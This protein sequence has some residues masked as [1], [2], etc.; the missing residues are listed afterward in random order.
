MAAL[1]RKEFYLIG[2]QIWS[3]IA[4][5]LLLSFI[6]QLESLG[7]S[8]LM[9][10]AIT[11]P[12]TTM[13]YDERCHWD[14]YLAMTP[15]RPE[16]IVCSKYLFAAGLTVAAMGIGLLTSFIQAASAHSILIEMLAEKI[17]VLMTVVTVNAI[18][19]PTVFRFGAEK[20]RLTMMA[21]M[22]A[23]FAVLIGE[24]GMF[25]WIDAAPPV[26]LWIAGIAVFAAVNIASF[27]L[28]VRL[29]RKRQA[30]AYD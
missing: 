14:T 9:V 28:S 21:V 30:G 7:S 19:L 17:G 15:C 27:F 8:Y 23:I 4:V 11:L 2:K 5:A 25:G 10:L 3:L 16:K 24:E 29:Y 1:M 22:L 6:P 13:A 20:G 12:M 18:T 26:P